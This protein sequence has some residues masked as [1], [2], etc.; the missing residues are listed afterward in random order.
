MKKITLLLLFVSTLSFNIF[1]QLGKGKKI[2]SG[3]IGIL[4]DSR[5]EKFKA[6]GTDENKEMFF[7]FDVNGGLFLKDN[8]AFGLHLGYD[9]YKYD[10][11]KSPDKSTKTNSELAIGLFGRF[12]KP[13]DLDR[14]ALMFH[15]TGDF[16]GG[17]G[18]N[19]SSIGG[20]SINTKSKIAGFGL[21]FTP[22]VAFLLSD[23]FAVETFYGNLGFITSK[24][25]VRNGSTEVSTVKNNDF[26]LDFTMQSLH[27]GV[28]YFF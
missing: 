8:F 15:F 5:S 18:T 9:Y 13:T 17:G 10:F 16:I 27:F 6:G 7:N 22:G 21:S 23:H 24:E 20:A 2:I 26:G 25:T 14:I 11:K 12:Y 4:N 19:K 3:S 1:A 28:S